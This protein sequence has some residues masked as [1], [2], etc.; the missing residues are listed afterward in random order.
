M[1]LSAGSPSNDRNHL[2]VETTIPR[3]VSLLSFVDYN[4]LSAVGSITTNL[5]QNLELV[6]KST[7]SFSCDK[8]SKGDRFCCAVGR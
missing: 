5:T 6:R 8:I 2:T 1:N 3:R 4:D 7:L